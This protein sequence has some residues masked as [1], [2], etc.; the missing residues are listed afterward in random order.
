[1]VVKRKPPLASVGMRPKPRQPFSS[2]FF[3]GSSGCAYLPAAL[4]CQ[5]SI[6]PSFTPAAVAVDQA[7]GDRDAL[8]LDARAGDVA[9][10][11]P[12]E[13]DVQVRADGL[14]AAGEQAHG[15]FSIGVSSRPRSTMSKR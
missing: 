5:I 7:P 12:V 15:I 13:A 1:M 3:C 9:R 14:V 6:R 10:G 2:G 8:A 4:A 11:E